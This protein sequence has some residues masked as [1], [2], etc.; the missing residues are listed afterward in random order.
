MP[1]SPPSEPSIYLMVLTLPTSSSPSFVVSC[2]PVDARV[3][4]TITCA[5]FGPRGIVTVGY[6]LRLEGEETGGHRVFTR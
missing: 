1:P 6:G 3:A 4:H 2:F 5:K